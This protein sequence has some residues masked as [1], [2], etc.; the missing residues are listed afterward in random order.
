M[1]LNIL[2]DG[3]NI[4]CQSLNSELTASDLVSWE[5]RDKER[6]RLTFNNIKFAKVWSVCPL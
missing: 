5:K 6:F 3:Q 4:R 1:F 2:K